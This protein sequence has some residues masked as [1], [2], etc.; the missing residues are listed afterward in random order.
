MMKTTKKINELIS[1]SSRFDVDFDKGLSDEQVKI[2]QK[3]GLSNKTKKQVTKTYPQIIF[4]NLFNFLNLIL[5]FVCV[6]MVLAK[7][8]VSHY[9]FLLILFANILIGLIQDIHARRMVDKLRVMVDPRAKVIRNGKQ[10]EIGTREVVLSDIISLSS[11]D[12]IC[13]DSIL[14]DGEIY[15]DESL[16]T[17]E[18]RPVKKSR[19]DTIYSGTFLIKGSCLA[20]VEKVGSANYAETL[21]SKA[22]GFSRPK[23]EIKH[24][25][26]VI[27]AV[28]GILALCF[29]FVYFLTYM[30]NGFKN[31]DSFLGVFGTMNPNLQSLIE[32]VSGSM[33]A[34]L[35][36]GMFLLTSLTLA[37]GVIVLAKK[38]IL[39]QQLYC[40]E[41]LARVDLLCLDKTGTLTD[42]TMELIE[43]IPFGK[44]RQNSEIAYVVSS[45]LFHTKDS[46][47]TANALK[48]A[49]GFSS[50]EQALE[51]IPFDSS[52]KYSAVSIHEEGTYIFGAYGFVPTKENEYIKTII[53]NKAREGYRCLVVARNKKYIEDGKVPNN[54]EIIGI[55]VLSDHIKDDAKE[56]IEWFKNSGV[57]IRV[58]SGDDPIT[59]SEIA[60]RVGVPNADK[61]ISLEGKT[62]EETAK[63]AN[64]YSVFGRVNPEQKAILVA[65]YKKNGHKVAMTGD[66]VNDILALKVA[67]CSIAMASGSE[68][69]R[70]VSHLVTL[71]SDFSKLPDVVAQGRR[72]INNLQRT[73]SLF[74]TKTAFATVFSFAFLIVMICNSSIKYPFSTSNMLV[75]E[76][77][78]I[79]VASFFLALQPSNEKLK[80]AFL[81]NILIK[82]IPAGLC[83]IISSAVPFV[84]VLLAPSIIST[85]SDSS[86]C[87]EA[88]KTCSVLMFT[89]MSY[90]VLFRVC[91]P[92]N[93]YRVILFSGLFV[94]GA[95]IFCFD[96]LLWNLNGRLSSS[97][98]LALSWNNIAYGFWVVAIFTCA[99]IGA[100]Y[101]LL[102]SKLVKFI[103]KIGGIKD[104]A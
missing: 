30:L 102:D 76:F 13:A 67:D 15:V 87:W 19:G 21:R 82:A 103:K 78:T 1:S 104:E 57:E 86:S 54:C 94:V 3:E 44:N 11:G 17:G 18:S 48:K 53:S 42:G 96:F 31:G 83:E 64:M 5:F 71:D 41:M 43:T 25:V 35:P 9:F 63:L 33:V 26:N 32:S 98:L 14:A 23:S 81:Q 62:D 79:G 69:A 59:V 52:L 29:G 2:R 100:I 84:L 49:F 50:T 4:D 101:I 91:V 37:V 27:V 73:C 58:I 88:A 68:A 36:T 70:N 61:Y 24:S 46:N 99:L 51:I 8:S 95:M 6:I 93:K 38:R 74:L 90:F 92:F 85:T 20:Q 60:K 7:L 55:L 40:I 97:P 75:W 16:L 65:S 80:G 22:A 34:M 10:I 77:A 45:I 72:V 66:G 56:N 39:V 47:P 89:L 12:Q 28:C